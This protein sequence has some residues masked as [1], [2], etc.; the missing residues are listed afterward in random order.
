[1]YSIDVGLTCEN[2]EDSNKK[3][4]TLAIVLGVVIPSAFLCLA[5]FVLLTL[6][7]SL[8]V[9][10]V[11]RRKEEEWNIEWDE[12]EIGPLL[13]EGGYGQVYKAEWKGTV[14]AVK[15]MQTPGELSKEVRNNFRDE[16]SLMN[17]LR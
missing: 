11:T 1:M 2:V 7:T 17:T 10:R 15:V 3:D 16:V 5:A 12:L 8:L 14:V 9:F 4:N 6:V 13:G